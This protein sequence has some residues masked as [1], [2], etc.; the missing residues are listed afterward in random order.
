MSARDDFHLTDY[1]TASARAAAVLD[2]VDALREMLVSIWLYVDWRYITKKLTTEQRERWLAAIHP[3][4]AA[5]QAEL[6][7]WA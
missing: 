4:D 6:R 2:E 3:E 1:M 5:M 7:W